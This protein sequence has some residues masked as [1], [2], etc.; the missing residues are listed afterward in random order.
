MRS[1]MTTAGIAVV[2][3]G[4][5]GMIE[6]SA[7]QSPAAPCTRPRWSTTALVSSAGPI[8]HVPTGCQ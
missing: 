8:L 4:T 2:A 6:Q 3:L 7:T 1:P 5:F